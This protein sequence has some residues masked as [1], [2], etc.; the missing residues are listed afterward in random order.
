MDQGEIVERGTHNELLKNPDGYYTKL[1]NAQ[2][3]K[4]DAVET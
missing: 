1:Y 2:F 4:E 3:K